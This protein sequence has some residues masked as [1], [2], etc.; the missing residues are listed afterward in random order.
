MV[1]FENREVIFDEGFARVV[2]IVIERGV[3]VILTLLRDDGTFASE[4]ALAAH[5]GPGVAAGSVPEVMAGIR[6]ACIDRKSV[7]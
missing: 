7:V 1:V 4:T 3:E 5:V 2:A 6:R